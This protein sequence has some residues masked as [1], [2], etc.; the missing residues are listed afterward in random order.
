MATD[1]PCV[2]D[3]VPQYLQ[4][5]EP[6]C[7]YYEGDNKQRPEGLPPFKTNDVRT[8]PIHLALVGNSF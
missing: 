3:P 1:S 8:V 7:R 5:H 6:Y 4:D 2:M